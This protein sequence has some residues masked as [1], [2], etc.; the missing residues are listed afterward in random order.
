M[1]IFC[2]FFGH[3]WTFWRALSPPKRRCAR[4]KKEQ[5]FNYGWLEWIDDLAESVQSQDEV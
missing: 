1:R 3:D 2:W 4:C 5:V